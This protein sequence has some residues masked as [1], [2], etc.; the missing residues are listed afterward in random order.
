MIN[1]LVCK[2][3]FFK[4]LRETLRWTPIGMVVVGFLCWQ[5]T[6]T[7]FNLYGSLAGQLVR[8][9][10][11]GA[12]LVALAIGLLQS[13]G[14]SRTDA[15]GFLLHRP[16]SL[17]SIFT[18]KLLAGF[19]AYWI[20]LAPPLIVTAIRLAI[21][22][23][24]RVP[25]SPLDLL[26]LV[27]S[28]LVIFMIHPAAMWT[29]YRTARWLGTRTLPIVFAA[30]G[31]ML[32]VVLMLESSGW[33]LL[34]FFPLVV[35]VWYLVTISAAW[36]AFSRETF[37]PTPASGE[38][39]SA[40]RAIG[41]FIA[42]V[43]VLTVL[44]VT[45]SQVFLNNS[46]QDFVIYDLAIENDGDLWEVQNVYRQ[47]VMFVGKGADK[48]ARRVSIGQSQ[49]DAFAPL[50]DDWQPANLISFTPYASAKWYDRFAFIGQIIDGDATFGYFNL[51]LHGG[52]ILVYGQRNGVEYIITPEGVFDPEDKPSGQFRGVKVL[53]S[54]ANSADVRLQLERNLL[55]IADSGIFQIELASRK[56]TQLVDAEVASAAIALPETKDESALLWAITN[57]RLSRYRLNSTAPD[58]P[59]ESVNDPIIR[60]T[61][62]YPLPPLNAEKVNDFAINPIEDPS[63]AKVAVIDDS[64]VVLKSP[65]GDFRYHVQS[66]SVDSRPTKSGVIR[67]SVNSTAYFIS[68]ELY[69]MPPGVIGVGSVVAYFIRDDIAWKERGGFSSAER[70]F[71]GGVIIHAL[72]AAALAFWIAARRG[73]SRT[74]QVWWAVLGVTFGVLALPAILVIHPKLVYEM[75]PECDRP[76]RIDTNRCDHCG[77]EWERLPRDG[78]EVIGGWLAEKAVHAEN[79]A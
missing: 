34:G 4:E 50:S 31:I 27:L 43:A 12:A 66:V 25:V 61:L 64:H 19:V 51:V 69:L 11:V 5:S 41:L 45:M 56:L 70:L 38:A 49:D 23:P 42:C 65:V 2:P 1:G 10:G 60:K 37:L 28:C 36:S 6:P 39:T 22:G 74:A 73:A 16:I 76:R 47:G 58:E 40:S 75:C 59:L 29:V 62:R 44:S 79:T 71:I 63:L 48:L 33:W 78:N 35:A 54:P 72:L 52:Q 77:A 13:L 17:R 67:T 14:D 18:T 46:Q 53:S 57:N 20:C 26:P 7:S 21:L 3:L 24:D 32:A 9:A 68:P 30:C 55:L 15:R 8:F